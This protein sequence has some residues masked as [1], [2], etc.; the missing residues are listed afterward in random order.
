MD[1]IVF[2]SEFEKK[3]T[4]PTG[5]WV[6]MKFATMIDAALQSDIYADKPWV[7]SPM[8]CSMNFCN[9]VKATEDVVTEC[10]IVKVQASKTSVESKQK[11]PDSADFTGN[12]LGGPD[13]KFIP[14][15]EHFTSVQ[16][17]KAPPNLKNQIGPW[18]WKD[19]ND[20]TENT[21]LLQ[22][23]K[24]LLYDPNSNS[25]RR[26]YYQKDKHRKAAILSSDKVHHFEVS[27][28]N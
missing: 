10:P 18:L 21:V 28:F 2:G 19:G 8:L 13:P 26:K 16:F 20:M 23:S 9:V 27:V 25:E 3:T 5:S 12:L 14:S 1:D 4:P 22:D 11:T 17:S 15:N 7:Y 24:T 6:A